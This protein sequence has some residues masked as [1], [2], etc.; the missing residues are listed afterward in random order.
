MMPSKDAL[1]FQLFRQ[2][3]DAGPA[4]FRATYWHAKGP[5]ASRLDRNAGLA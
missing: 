2:R 4:R 1:I 5:P 3:F